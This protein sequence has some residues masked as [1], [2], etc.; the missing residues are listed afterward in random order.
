MKKMTKNEISQ[1]VKITSYYLSNCSLLLGKPAL[2]QNLFLRNKPNFNHLN[3]SVTSC[4]TVR[5][6][7]LR[8]KHKIGTNP[9][10]ANFNLCDLYGKKTGNTLQKTK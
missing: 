2:S 4:V 9:I 10:K 5:Y 7:A 1:N 3:I 8:T 6:N